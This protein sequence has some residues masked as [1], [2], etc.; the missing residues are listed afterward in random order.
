MQSELFTY[1]E[2]KLI[3]LVILTELVYFGDTSWFDCHDTQIKNHS[4]E[5]S[6]GQKRLHFDFLW[7]QCTKIQGTKNI[8]FFQDF[9]KEVLNM[10]SL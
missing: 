5:A 6:A 7:S 8:S 2:Y 10:R 1:R 3:L 9:F 4:L